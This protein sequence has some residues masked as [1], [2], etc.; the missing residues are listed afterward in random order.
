MKFGEDAV[1]RNQPGLQAQ[2]NLLVLNAFLSNT[3][4]DV[5]LFG[6]LA[7]CS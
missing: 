4:A 6:K 3:D 1:M 7:G 2:I 5:L